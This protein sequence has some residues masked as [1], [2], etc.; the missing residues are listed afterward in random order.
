M[1][2]DILMA[3]DNSADIELTITALSEKNLANRL[4]VVRDG[5]EAID[6]LECT[7]DYK[8]RKSGNP[9][10]IMLDIKMPR[11]DGIEVLEYIK[12]DSRFKTIPVV[13][14]TSSREDC[15]L[16]KAY[17]L[18]VNAYVVKPVSFN[19]FMEAIRQI[20]IFWA[21]LNELPPR[22]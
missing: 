15:D 2:Y 17:E 7:G 12:K 11:M 22:H 19:Q 3:E 4:I 9:G 16:H 13:M 21:L 14:L 20:G 5:V 18:G 6:Y 8:D 10:L 1:L